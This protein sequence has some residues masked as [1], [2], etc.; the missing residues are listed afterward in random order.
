MAKVNDSPVVFLLDTGS[1]LTILRR[2]VWERCRL[3]TQQLQPWNQKKLIGSGGTL[4]NV[5]G[6]TTIE[7]DVKNEKFS[8]SVMIV[9]PLAT[10]AIL[11]LD[12]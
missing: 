12:F 11:G 4:L 7:I 1:A 5:Y 8:Q 10:K 9:D 3:S 2:N 6:W